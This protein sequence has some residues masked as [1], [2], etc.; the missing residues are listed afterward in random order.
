[1]VNFDLQGRKIGRHMDLSAGIDNLLDKKYY[2]PPSTAVSESAIQ[3]DGR[4]YRLKL[5]W[6]LGER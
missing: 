3:Q 1:M 2:D 4:T 5:T 6:H